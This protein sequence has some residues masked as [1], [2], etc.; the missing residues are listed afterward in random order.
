MPAA[1][2]QQFTTAFHIKINGAD[3]A[4]DQIRRVVEVSIEQSL[5]LPDMVMIRLHDVGD[6]ANSRQVAFFKI[7][8]DNAFPIGGA[9]EIAMGRNETPATVFK[10]EITAVDLEVS[11]EQAPTVVVRGYARSHRLHRGRQSMSFQ[12]VTDSD[13]ASKIAMQA[14][15]RAQTDATKVTHD[16]L[17]QNNQ[18]NWE[19]LKER[20]A[21]NGYEMF[22]DDKTLYFRKPIVNQDPAPD[23]NLWGNLLGLRVRVSSSFQASEVVVRG[24]DPKSKQAI[25]GRASSGQLAPQLG[26]GKTGAQ[27]AHDFGDSKVYVVNRPVVNQSEADTL[28]QA[29]YNSLDGSFVQAEGTCI[30]DP[31]IKPGKTVNLKTIGQQLSGKYYVS[32]V[33][34]RANPTE[35]YVSAFVVSGRQTNSLLDLIDTAREAS[36]V[37]SVV[38]GVVTDNT[39]PDG[40]QGRVKVK[41]PWLAEND[42]SWWARIASPMAGNDRGFYFLPEI[43]DEVLVSFEHGDITRPYIIGA[44]WNGKD[45]PPKPNSQVV[46]GSKVNERIIKT[47]AGH[48]ISLD[49]TDG[50][51]KISIIDKTGKNLIKIESSTN[52][53][54]IQ[55]EGDIA[56]TA[57]GKVN[58]DAQQDVNVNTQANATVKTQ[59]NVNVEAT[60]NATVKATGNATVQATGNLEL[61]GAMVSLEAQSA[62]TIKA[63]ATLTIQGAIVNIN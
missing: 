10:G 30:G 29:V 59:Q 14:G 20:A 52:Q 37:P 12:N 25:V 11:G 5:H 56:V 17:Y 23:L 7:L 32:S 21:R 62:M 61:K 38:I 4:A 13:V 41:F 27:V 55:A 48:I 16:Y 35:G 40:N 50:S 54:S 57:K 46:S 49:D 18:T 58:V 60:G 47:R 2:A 22:V 33:T 39:D 43:D 6:D 26:M 24:W 9:I 8:D 45:A 1:S 36:P 44:L 53:I 31:E 51:E 15:L 42:Q 34:H 28:A 19:F 63:N 3:L